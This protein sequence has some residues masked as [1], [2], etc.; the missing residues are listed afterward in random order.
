M[1]RVGLALL[2]VGASGFVPPAIAAPNDPF[3]GKWKL[4]VRR[5]T[6]VDEVR[7]EVLGANKYAFSFEGSP[8]ESVVAD[9]TDQAGLPG[10]TLAVKSVDPHRLTVVR[11]QDGKVIVS[12]A[13]TLSDDGRTL[14]DAFTNVQADGSKSTTNYLY[15]R[16]SG[17]SGFAGTWESTTPP[18]GLNLELSIEPAGDKA[19]RFVSPGSD[20]RVMFD[21]KGHAVRGS[22][23]V[24]LSGRRASARSLEYDERNKG[25]IERIRQFKLSRDGRTLKETIHVAGQATPTVFVFDRE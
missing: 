21:G 9:G 6:I 7:V 20:R 14:H 11:K 8:T 13:W 23:D 24:V 3:A 22:Q 25:K 12:A 18:V 5:S 10:T 1:R 19:L 17:T 16:L 2:V 4:D 15:R